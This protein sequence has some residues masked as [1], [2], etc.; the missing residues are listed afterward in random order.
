VLA[1]AAEMPTLNILA[2]CPNRTVCKQEH[3]QTLV[4]SKEGDGAKAFDSLQQ[5]LPL[6]RE[7]RG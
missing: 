3:Y 5:Q 1:I 6:V 2:K 7:V 4:A